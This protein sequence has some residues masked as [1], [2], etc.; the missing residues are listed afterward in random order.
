MIG[1]LG[2]A[3]I[4]EV[5]ARILLPADLAQLRL[6]GAQFERSDV[7]GIPF[8]LRP[9]V[10]GWTNNLGLCNP[11]DVAAEKAPGTFRLLVVGDSVSSLRTDG[12]SPDKLF[13]NVLEGL[14]A[15]RVGRPLQVLNLSSPG[16]STEQELALVRARGLALQP[17]LILLAYAANDPVRTDIATAA[18]VEV[19]RWFLPLQLMQL[20]IYRR[21]P[22]GTPDE[23]Y[24]PGSDAF[25]RLDR[26]F[27]ELARL[28]AER[29]IVVVPL[30]VR[31]TDKTQ[32]IHL[33]AVAELCRRHGMRS[34]DIYP[35]MLPYL[36]TL[37][38]RE[39]TDLLHFDSAGHRAVAEAL[40]EPLAA[41][42]AGE[43]NRRRGFEAGS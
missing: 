37:N 35:P 40:V 42:L 34:L 19:A 28:S 30:P 10:P 12:V 26:T 13:P 33:D 15:E 41:L 20:W 4:A 32:Q 39:V 8:L 16:L 2:G 36:S 9:G 14:L 18:N 3:L 17:D 31:S 24:R 1:V 25:Q 29:P 43:T 27:G 38:P 21:Q 6:P 23:W 11:R 22:L 5:G 7:P